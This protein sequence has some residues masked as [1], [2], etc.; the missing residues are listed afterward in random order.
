MSAA[1]DNFGRGA[2]Q[3]L[4]VELKGERIV[5]SIGVETL[6][7]AAENMPNLCDAMAVLRVTDRSVFARSVLD[8]LKH[9]EE[10]GTTF[11]HEA[12]D[13]AFDYV[14]EQGYEGCEIEWPS[15]EELS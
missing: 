13:K 2:N 8:A 9:E 10:D 4:R 7:V 3:I 15:E 11:V 5:I 6:K 1:N 14:V 12:I